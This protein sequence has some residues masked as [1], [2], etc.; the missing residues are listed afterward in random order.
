MWINL[1]LNAFQEKSG[2]SSTRGVASSPTTSTANLSSSDQVP[3][4]PSVPSTED[5]DPGV[6][7]RSC[8]RFS[9]RSKTWRSD[10]PSKSGEAGQLS[11]QETGQQSNSPSPTYQSSRKHSLTVPGESTHVRTH[12]FTHLMGHQQK[13]STSASEPSSLG[14]KKLQRSRSPSPLS[15][16]SGSAS[17]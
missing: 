11:G 13:H 14:S 5:D 15:T 9:W 12:S 8:S 1:I 6:R 4:S 3:R 16:P 7:S 10:S 2:S 17:L